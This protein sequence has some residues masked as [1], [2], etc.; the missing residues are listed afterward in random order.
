MTVTELRKKLEQ[1]ESEGHGDMQVYLRNDL[2]S[3]DWDIQSINYIETEE[4]GI[5]LEN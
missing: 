3:D 1:L 2:L 4:Q 5:I